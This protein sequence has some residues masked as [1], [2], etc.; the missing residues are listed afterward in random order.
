MAI[1][2]ACCAVDPFT[3][4]RNTESVEAAQAPQARADSTL[5]PHVALALATIAVEP[6]LIYPL[7]ITSPWPSQTS[8]LVKFH[9]LG[10]PS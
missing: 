1:V 9:L 7:S 2:D 6:L 4:Q 8:G 10:I 3:A 5:S